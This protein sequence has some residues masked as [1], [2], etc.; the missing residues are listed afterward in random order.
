MPSRLPPLASR[1]MIRAPRTAPIT[2]PFAP[3]RLAPPM[4]APA[5]ACNSYPVPAVGMPAP[6]RD[7]VKTPAKPASR[8]LMLYTASSTQFTGTPERR[9][10]EWRQP[11]A[12]HEQ[13]VD[14]ANEQP[15]E[16]AD[17]DG[18][19]DGSTAHQKQ[20]RHSPAQA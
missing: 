7:V 8:P 12:R 3:D 16:K 2:R 13:P 4:T 19:W 9:A 20:C 11:K 17:Q 5:M 1:P 6:R 10:D 18:E 15:E 14:Q